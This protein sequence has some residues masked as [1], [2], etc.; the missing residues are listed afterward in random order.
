MSDVPPTA[1]WPIPEDE[2]RKIQQAGQDAALAGQRPDACPYRPGTGPA[3][4]EDRFRQLMWIRGFRN[5]RAQV[6][7]D[8]PE[9]E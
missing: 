1:A 9:P 7:A 5:A 4:T 3:D 2:I 8:R 6:E